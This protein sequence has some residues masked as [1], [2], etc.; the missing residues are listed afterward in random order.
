MLNGNMVAG[1]SKRGLLLRVGKER[2]AETVAE[3]GMRA[4]EQ[5]GRVMEGYVYAD[6]PPA[7]DAA[8]RAAF[9]ASVRTWSSARSSQ[10]PK[11]RESRRG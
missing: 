9:G 11:R 2:H 1:T 10:A 8:L 7:L 5:R 4:M 6:P 3:P